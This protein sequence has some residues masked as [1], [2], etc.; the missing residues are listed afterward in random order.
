MTNF[1]KSGLG[2]QRV[3]SDST[4]ASTQDSYVS[5]IEDLEGNPFEGK[6]SWDEFKKEYYQLEKKI[7]KA[8]E[9]LHVILIEF[10]KHIS[11]A[12]S[13]SANNTNT[14]NLYQDFQNISLQ[15]KDD[16]GQMGDLFRSLKR[17]KGD[18][19]ELIKQN[20]LKRF[21]E[22]HQEH[23]REFTRLNNSFELNKKKLE[24]FN[25]T[26]KLGELS[27]EK[28][29]NSSTALMIEQNQELSEAV[30]MSTRVVNQAKAV[31]TSFKNQSVR[32]DRINLQVKK[33]IEEFGSVS[34]ILKKIKYFKLKKTIAILIIVV[35]LAIIVLFKIF[36]RLA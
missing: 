24:L 27:V 16:L 13:K 25:E 18:M 2:F 26:L 22:I 34:D 20:M 23:E 9:N 33:L 21:R 31:S 8:L 3:P 29:I 7:K 36:S 1:V 14:A 30:A 35:I 10:T 19:D 17:N 6:K 11:L 15:A 32:L 12:D 4:L 5:P 28:K